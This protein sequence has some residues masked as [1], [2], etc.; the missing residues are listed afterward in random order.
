MKNFLVRILGFNATL[1]QGDL[2]VLDRW[3][4]LNKQ[5]RNSPK[6][7][8]LDVGSGS[9]AFTI[10]AALKYNYMALG[11]SW[12]A[13]N[14]KIS[15]E[16]A[17]ILRVGQKAFFEICDVRDLDK[18]TDLTDSYDVVICTEN[19][20]HIINDVKLVRD[21]SMTLKVGGVL[22]L[23]TPNYN[24]IPMGIGD[25]KNLL[26]LEEDGGHVRIGYT[27]EDC[28]S[29]C[30]KANLKIV[31]IEYCSGFFSQKLTAL[32]RHLTCYL[33]YYP[34][35][36]ITFP[37]RIFPI[38]FDKAIEKYMKYPGYSICIIAKK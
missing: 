17:S 38:V 35:W 22:L 28:I 2:L 4:W 6:G 10:G 30:E 13:R 7:K 9:G 3:K 27:P 1:I 14:K 23:T 25:D 36:I 5:L 11:L 26:S 21:I 16:R 33:S 8:L 34:A 20:E 24:Y 29:V 32:L 31:K 12:D 15:E 19:I 37:L 18:R